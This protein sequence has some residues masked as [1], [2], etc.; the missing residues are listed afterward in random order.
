M[1]IGLATQDNPSPEQG[2]LLD[3]DGDTVFIYWMSPASLELSSRQ[4]PIASQNI[5]FVY[6]EWKVQ[7][8]LPKVQTRKKKL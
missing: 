4:L 8:C 3:E 2:D 7:I 1:W 6:G 5:K